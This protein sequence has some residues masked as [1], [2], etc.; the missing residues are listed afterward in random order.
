[1]NTISD[2]ICDIYNYIKFSAL[3]T[4]NLDLNKDGKLLLP[5]YEYL[6]QGI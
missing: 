5:G 4:R 6:F 1:M 2:L 3:L